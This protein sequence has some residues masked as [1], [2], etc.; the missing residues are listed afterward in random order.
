MARI[1]SLVVRPLSVIALGA[2]ALAAPAYADS[3][4]DPSEAII[5][6]EAAIRAELLKAAG[7]SKT[8]KEG[9]EAYRQQQR[10]QARAVELR[11]TLRQSDLMCQTMATQ[12]TASAGQ[13]QAHGKIYSGQRKA[14]QAVASN[15]GTVAALDSAHK[16]SN[17]RYCTPQEAALGVCQATTDARYTNLA[18]ADQ[19]AMF[20]FQSREGGSS[21]DGGRDGAQV[22]A[23]DGYIRRVVAGVPPEQLRA[24]AAT[25]R[26]SP[27]ARAYIEL[28]RRYQAFLS[29]AAY[30]LNQIKESRNPLK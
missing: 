15:T 25:Y 18:G 10:L 24:Q 9:L 4:G 5:Q 23:V 12:D 26:N 20:L 8:V 3:D 2:L 17:E 13:R 28:Q 14:L 21:Y 1:R 16:V 22:D 7:A 11:E 30:S 27:Q 6:S 19:N 29:M